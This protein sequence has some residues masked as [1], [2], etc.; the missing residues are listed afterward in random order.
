MVGSTTAVALGGFLCSLDRP[1]SGLLL[2][3]L[4][5]LARLVVWEVRWL[6]GGRCWGELLATVPSGG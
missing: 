4:L 5:P 2:V 6:C 1:G 3:A